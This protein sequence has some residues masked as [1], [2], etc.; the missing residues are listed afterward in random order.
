MEQRLVL[1][2]LEVDVWIE[3]TEFEA[4]QSDRMPEDALY[5]T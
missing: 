1:G 4:A 2:Q 3:L 5:I